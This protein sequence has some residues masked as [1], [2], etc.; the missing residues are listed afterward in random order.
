MNSQSKLRQQL[1]IQKVHDILD[2][3]IN[4]KEVNDAFDWTDDP[5]ALENMIVMKRILC[6]VLSHDEGRW[7]S[8]NMQKLEEALAI[9]GFKLRMTQ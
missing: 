7:L 6:W 3:V 4:N 8:D 2:E 9:R 1:E 5:G